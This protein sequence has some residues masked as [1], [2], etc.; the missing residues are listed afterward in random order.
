M[1]AC[2]FFGAVS[3]CFAAWT[4]GSRALCPWRLQFHFIS[5]SHE[6]AAGGWCRTLHKS[7][8]LQCFMQD[9]KDKQDMKHCMIC[10]AAEG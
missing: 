8:P 9:M 10:K 6:R 4:V 2:G 5:P 3:E 1:G 7:N